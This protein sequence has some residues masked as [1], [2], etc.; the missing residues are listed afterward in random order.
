MV[1]NDSNP[2]YKKAAEAY[3]HAKV[4]LM[5]ATGLG[6][7]SVVTRA[8]GLSANVSDVATVISVVGAGKSLAESAT[9]TLKAI[10][11][12]PQEDY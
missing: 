2:H 7:V 3:Q 1:D 9:E 6:S 5:I 4:R 12:Q 10:D 11:N 8:A